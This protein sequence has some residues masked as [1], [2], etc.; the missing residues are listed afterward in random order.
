MDVVEAIDVTVGG[1]ASAPVS[2]DVA[3]GEIV[4]A[5]GRAA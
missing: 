3:T 4:G 1:P 2:L 5:W